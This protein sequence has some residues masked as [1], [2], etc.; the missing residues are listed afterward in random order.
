MRPPFPV[1]DPD[2]VAS[3]IEDVLQRPRRSV[4]VRVGVTNPVIIA[5]YRLLPAVY[6]ALVAPL[7]RLASVTRTSLAPTTG[8][9]LHAR[10]DRDRL[11]GRTG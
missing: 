11:H 4:S 1:A 9:V 10:P 5:G 8:N 3:A 2:R 7:F 6:D